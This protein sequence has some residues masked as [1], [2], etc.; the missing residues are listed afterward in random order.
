MQRAIAVT[1]LG[2]MMAASGP[3]VARAQTPAPSLS[4]PASPAPPAKPPQKKTPPEPG[5]RPNTRIDVTPLGY[6]PPGAFYLTYR[7][8]SASLSFIDDD[9][10][11]F[12]FR[13]GGLLK[14]L[15]S[16]R[17]G[18]DD[19]QI[20]AMVLDAR[21][22]QVVRQ[23]EWRM[24]DRSQYLWSFPDGKFLVRMRD[25]LYLT[26][27]SLALKPYVSF[28]TD[29]REIQV[30][31]D[32]RILVVERDDPPKLAQNSAE[33]QE[34]ETRNPVRV[35]VMSSGST[36][37]T[38][39]RETESPVNVPLVAD[40]ILDTLEGNQLASYAVREVPFAGKVRILAQVK[41]T[42][43]PTLQT[44]SARVALVVGCYQASDDRPVVAISTDGKELWREQ[45]DNKYVWGWFTSA[46]NGSRFAYESI[47][48]ARPIS[49]FDELDED[50]I[51]AQLVGVYDTES[52]KL[53]MVKNVTPVL[54]A[55]QNVT[56]SPDGTR[57]AV[58]RNGA[59]EV[60]DLPPVSSPPAQ[61]AASAP[62]APAAKGK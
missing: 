57:F 30:S 15:P 10:L 3:S 23:T 51:T 6:A 37:A 13:V 29:L 48:V 60:Y 38:V 56:L 16:D 43:Q 19:Q 21:T 45:W 40:G 7:L 39:L 14:R 26:D 53:V 54:T 52:G 47:E 28:D 5:P 62:K 59:I 11:L 44:V 8:T 4:Q 33:P 20:R 9:H 17:D 12:T 49:V 18:D 27:A 34:P 2:M 31:P 22:G 1:A 55:G 25:T 42:C 35:E 46:Q 50:D 32:R 36:A 61:Q 41:S 24:H 58:L